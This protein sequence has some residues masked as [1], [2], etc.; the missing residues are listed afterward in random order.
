ML[1]F[2]KFLFVFGIFIA[3]SIA[4]LA[5]VISVNIKDQKI[6]PQYRAILDSQIAVPSYAVDGY[7]FFLG[8]RAATAEQ[9][10]F[11][12]GEAIYKAALAESK[13]KTKTIPKEHAVDGMP[14]P[15][16][17]DLL[18][19]I[20]GGYITKEKWETNK[21]EVEAYL[22]KVSPHL[23]RFDKLMSYRAYALDQKPTFAFLTAPTMLYFKLARIKIAQLN[24]LLHHGKGTDYLDGL[25]EMNNFSVASLQ[26]PDT[27]LGVMINVAIL[28][29]IH[30]NYNEA[31]KEYPALKAQA[32]QYQLQKPPSYEQILKSTIFIE[33][34]FADMIF[35]SYLDLAELVAPSAVAGDAM[36][37]TLRFAVQN[38]SFALP[39]FYKP[40]ATFNLYM[41]NVLANE[42][43]PCV[44]TEVECPDKPIVRASFIQRTIS[45]P[46][47]ASVAGNVFGL[48]AN[49]FKKLYKDLQWIEKN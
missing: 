32:L 21:T 8:L 31:L 30:E 49:R 19:I 13:D 48:S 3:V 29:H 46:I 43:D 40:N 36:S 12:V 35:H 20:N 18:A 33:A 25:V 6:E 14:L 17:E 5:L 24:Q 27:M 45:N 16:L 34:H 28:R 26:L 15:E 38:F 1:N 39:I 9:D 44:K 47:G 23:K 11:V 37:P 10:P 22:Q 41:Q 42:A 4:I 2:R 7:K